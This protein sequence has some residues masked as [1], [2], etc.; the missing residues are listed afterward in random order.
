MTATALP[1]RTSPTTWLVALSASCL[2]LCVLHVWVVDDAFITLRQVQQLLLGNGFVWNQGER[3][4]A[5][6]H[7]LWALLMVPAFALTGEGFWTLAVLSLMT[8]LAGF[9]V[10]LAALWRSGTAWRAVA[11]L[12]LLL[13]SKAFFDY[14]SSGLENCLTHLLVVAT[15]A[16]LWTWCDAAAPGDATHLRRGLF[17]LALLTGLTYLNRADTLLLVLPALLLGAARTFRLQRWRAAAPVALGLAPVLLWTAWSV[18]YY[19]SPVPNTAIAKITGARLTTGERLESGLL[20]ALDSVLRDPWTLLLAATA[21]VLLAARRQAAA[22]AAAAGL[23]LYLLYVTVLGA[24]GTH[25]SGRFYSAVACLAAFALARSLHDAGAGTSLRLAGLAA[26]AS[27]AV[28]S[29]PLQATWRPGSYAFALTNFHRTIDTRAVVA[30]EGASLL[31]YQRGMRMPNHT[32]FKAGLAFA[33]S[34]ERVHVGGM[35]EQGGTDAIGYSAFAAGPDKYVVDRLALTD[36]LLARLP[37]AVAEAFDRPGHVKRELPAGYL[38]SIETD[39]NRI[40]DPDL[41]AYYDRLRLVVRGPLWSWERLQ[42]IVALNL[43]QYDHLLARYA[44][45][46]GLRAP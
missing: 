19:G 24:A 29:S 39:S 21:I 16:R 38:A 18:L 41:H 26:L 8:T 1:D 34:P 30:V 12:L 44:A 3:V 25:M 11:F 22:V 43:G 9:A 42:T 20:Y 17:A 31:S 46:A 4:Q 40:E 2:L 28:P 36:P 23:T 10:A 15:Y 14:T 37:L 13:P 6:T 5:Y 32:W 27:F 35:G 45:R 33:Q 7:P